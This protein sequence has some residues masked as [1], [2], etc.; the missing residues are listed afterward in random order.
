MPF[1]AQARAVISALELGNVEVIADDLHDLDA[2]ALGGP[3]IWPI[4]GSS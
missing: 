2:A 1:C 4:R 3:S